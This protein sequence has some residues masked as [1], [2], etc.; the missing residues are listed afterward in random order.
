MAERAFTPALGRVMHARFYD[1]IIALTG[2]RRWRG[3]V[4][5]QLAPRAD[6]VIVDVGCG[7]GTMALM[8]RQAAPAARI[9]GLD[10]D[11]DVLAISRRNAADAGLAVEWSQCMGDALTD[12]LAP[13]TASKL[14][15]SLV[16]HQCPMS[17]KRAILASMFSVLR[18]GGKLVATRSRSERPR[19]RA[20]CSP[21]RALRKW[22]SHLRCG[23]GVQLRAANRRLPGVSSRPWI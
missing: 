10:P 20:G 3:L 2:Q 14:T 6:D 7:T 8:L 1:P 5:A 22:R 18:S 11:P 13:G 12:C 4:L 9:L 15:S 17:M 19:A 21:R 23:R 16:L